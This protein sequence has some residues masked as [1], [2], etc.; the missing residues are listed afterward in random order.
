MTLPK[1][2]SAWQP[3]SWRPWLFGPQAERGA[4]VVC[5]SGHGMSIGG[6]QR[7][8]SSHGI[9]AEGRV[10]PSVVCHSCGWHVSV[11]LAGWP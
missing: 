7:F 11:R 2:S 3:S 4:A 5:P 1:A 6:G 9:D 10:S 8:G